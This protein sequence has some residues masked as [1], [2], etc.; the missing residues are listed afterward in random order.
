MLVGDLI[1]AG[2][3]NVN[4]NRKPANVRLLM[5]RMTILAWAL[6]MTATLTRAEVRLPSA[7]SEH[8]VLQRGVPVHIWGWA[9][10]GER[11][12]AHFHNQAR[13]AVADS[14]GR[15]QVW[16]MPESAGGP[17]TLTVE[18]SETAK[19]LELSD[20][21]VGDVWLASGQPNME[22]P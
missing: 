12:S 16:L 17:Y 20:I 13:E 6:A 3:R 10:P 9:A 22:F 1:Q 2:R 11:V 8:A 7:F 19:P 5:M 18:G 21:L 14:D 15:W 4:L